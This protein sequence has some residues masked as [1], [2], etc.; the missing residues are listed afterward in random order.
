MYAYNGGS[1]L[2]LAL[3]YLR[4]HEFVQVRYIVDFREVDAEMLDDHEHLLVE[5]GSPALNLRHEEERQDSDEPFLTLWIRDR[6]ALLHLLVQIAL[7]VLLRELD[8]LDDLG[9][10]LETI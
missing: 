9:E 4:L 6:A 5:E 2:L 3:I 1:A 7:N 8:S 10:D